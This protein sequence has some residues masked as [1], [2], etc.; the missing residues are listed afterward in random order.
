MLRC[1]LQAV[2]AVGIGD[3]AAAGCALWLDCLYNVTVQLHHLAG[4]QQQLQ[5]SWS[6]AAI[7]H[8]QTSWGSSKQ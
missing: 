2:W 6:L 7:K 8:R 4:L 3:T 5:S 1:W